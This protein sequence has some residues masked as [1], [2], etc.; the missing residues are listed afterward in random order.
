MDLDLKDRKLLYELDKDSRQT[1]SQISK[2]IRLNKNTTNFR[3]NRLIR[4]GYIRRFYPSVDLSKLGY[5]TFRIYFKFFNTK[6]NIEKGIIN[7]LNKNKLVGAVAELESIYDVMFMVVVKNVYEFQN[8]FDSFKEKYRNYFWKES[9]SLVTK[10]IHLK[11][12]YLLERTPQTSFEIL[13]EAKEE[14]HDKKDIKILSELSKNCRISVLEISEKLKIPSKTV[15]FRIKQL[16]KKK[17]IQ[18]YRLEL[19]LD[20]I[21]YS[22]YKINFKF[23]KNQK[24]EDLIEYCKNNKNLVFID[25]SISEYDFEIEIEVENKNQVFEIINQIKQKFGNI[26]EYEVINFKKYDKI[27]SI[28]FS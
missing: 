27:E 24:K 26:L 9:I 28:P 22:Y 21:G 4:E 23:N 8:F 12:D 14:K 10:I 3:L 19:N 17:I 18:G 2:K 5:M 20:K 16:E 13:G 15:A 6:P 1:I 7:Y 11:R 25:F